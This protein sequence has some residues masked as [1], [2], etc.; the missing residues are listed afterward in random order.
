V[1]FPFGF[2]LS[3][4]TFALADLEVTTHGDVAGG[5][6]A[7]SVSLTVTNTGTVDG[8]EVVQVYVRDP[9][10]SV[11]RPVRELKGFAKVHLAAGA[12]QR[13]SVQ[14]DQRAFSFWST[15][16]GRWAVEAGDFVVEVGTSSRDLPL[17]Q[18]VDV[19]AP[20]L[21]PPLSRDSTL[22]EWMADPVGRRLV[23][24]EV[25]QGQSAAVLED[26][27]VEVIGNMPMSTLASFGGM[28]LDHDALDRVAQEWRDGVEEAT[29]PTGLE[30]VRP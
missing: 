25:A 30:P 21:D 23:E 28:S 24:R 17:H 3:Y 7:A 13:V 18:T 14:L 15:L 5:T 19:D 1:A 9:E 26:D 4:T 11:A 29:S 8:A 10:C 22:Q 2:G 16:H 6:L 20:R 27:L 12:S